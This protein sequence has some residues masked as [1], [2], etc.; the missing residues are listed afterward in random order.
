LPDEDGTAYRG[1]YTKRV[2][3]TSG[4]DVRG[5][6]LTD[7]QQWPPPRL[8]AALASFNSDRPLV[9]ELLR[10]DETTVTA[11]REFIVC[12]CLDR[13]PLY[14]SLRPADALERGHAALVRQQCVRLP[15]A[16]ARH[17]LAS[18]ATK[19]SMAGDRCAPRERGEQEL[20][21]RLRE[22]TASS[23]CRDVSNRHEGPHHGVFL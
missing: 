6:T 8:P 9:T 2:G 15:W 17:A 3:M 23:R 13:S 10:D 12:V 5:A 16:Q 4:Y 18:R 11:E 20:A 14:M 19:R 7:S 21:P 1:F 22:P